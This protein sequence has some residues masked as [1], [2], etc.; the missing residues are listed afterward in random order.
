MSS[1]VVV[2]HSTCLRPISSR[3]V[4]SSLQRYK[5]THPEHPEAQPKRSPAR[6]P[7]Y[8]AT[9]L[10]GYLAT[11]LLGYLATWLLGYL[12]T[13]L[14]GYLATWLL[15]YLA[16]WLLGYLA[17][18][19]LGYLATWLL[20]YLATWLLGYSGPRYFAAS[21]RIRLVLPIAACASCGGTP[22]SLLHVAPS[23]RCQVEPPDVLFFP[24]FDS[25]AQG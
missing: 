9:W 15:G 18:W 1:S 2:S 14:L 25:S 24:G 23:A 8:L 5:P 4:P 6:S 17:T 13:W 19:L 7:R 10:L 11:W 12:A 20:G 21:V 3:Q 16:T 22:A